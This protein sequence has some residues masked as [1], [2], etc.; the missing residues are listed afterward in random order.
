VKDRL[1]VLLDQDECAGDLAGRDLITEEIADLGKLVLI[2]MRT[3]GNIESAFGADR[4]RRPQ[5]QR[6]TGEHTQQL[7]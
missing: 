3:G 5:H 2:E 7:T 4:R 1:A 6:A